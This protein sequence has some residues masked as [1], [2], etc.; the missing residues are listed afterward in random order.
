MSIPVPDLDDRA[1]QQL[2]DDAKRRIAAHCPEWTDHNVSD[3]GVTLVELFATMTEEVIYRL[4]RLP[5]NM[6]L[7][8]MGLVG[9]RLEPGRPARTGL[10]FWLTA[11]ARLWESTEEDVH[12]VSGPGVEV[13]TERA[14]AGEPPISFRTTAEIALPRA[15]VSAR[16]RAPAEAGGDAEPTRVDTTDVA[17]FGDGVPEPGAA[18]LLEL[19]RPLPGCA[20]RLDLVCQ[21]NRGS[22]I[23]P[24]DPPWAWEAWV[25]G[26]WQSCEVDRDTTGGLNRSGAVYIHVPMD[27]TEAGLPGT[28]SS[29]WLRCRVETPRP[30]Q[31]DYD[32]SPVVGAVTAQT[33]GVTVPATQA[34]VVVRDEVVGVSDGSCGQ[35]PFQLRQAPVVEDGSGG[36][37]L[38]AG[39]DR[40]PWRPVPDFRD[41]SENDRHYLL[42]PVAGQIR[43]GV[44]VRQTDGRMRRHGR[45][46]PAG[47]VL[48]VAR[49]DVSGGTSGNVRANAVHVLRS[50]LPGIRRAENR[51][52]AVGGVDPET[53][54]QAVTRLPIFL[55]RRDRAV[56]VADF[57]EDGPR[58]RSRGRAQP[59]GVV[60][61]CRHVGR[62][63]RGR[64][65]R[66]AQRRGQDDTGSRTAA[67]RRPRA[68]VPGGATP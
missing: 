10:T 42:D 6:L 28:P 16:Y 18:F 8:F 52:P 68:V 67:H 66:G 55:R 22:G 30:G 48:R 31:G 3:P 56:T 5:A 27:H 36:P 2:V 32:A 14:T 25:H 58:R 50:P 38:V 23:D 26:T 37:L 17:I 51:H 19:A 13:S 24:D 35:P 21:A 49:Y 20:V 9:M 44:A 11:P 45:I 57:A 47:A 64:R 34:D 29:S 4:N 54:E 1:F 53:V 46:P 60:R 7:T 41:S 43:L 63:P 62:G 33:I 59:R 39:D 40:E 61:G 12:V 65:P 15:E